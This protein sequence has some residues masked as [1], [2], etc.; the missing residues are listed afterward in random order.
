MKWKYYYYFFYSYPRKI[1]SLLTSPLHIRATSLMGVFLETNN[2]TTLKI[3][4]RRKSNRIN[5]LSMHTPT[6]K[7]IKKL[8]R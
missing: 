4:F 7:Y 6:N 5:Q 1:I 2:Q 8:E 3:D